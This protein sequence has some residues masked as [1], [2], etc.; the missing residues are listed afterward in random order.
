MVATNFIC[1]K[2][3]TR[4]L[5]GK[6][7]CVYHVWCSRENIYAI[8]MET[9]HQVDTPINCQALESPKSE[10]REQSHKLK[11]LSIY[12]LRY[13][14]RQG[15]IYTFKVKITLNVLS[16]V[17]ISSLDLTTIV[18]LNFIISAYIYHTK[19]NFN[20]IFLL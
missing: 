4:I 6:E 2:S 10:Q 3:R 11:G 13:N 17:Y 16:V 5:G 1:Q 20:Y 15:Y 12:N 8:E 18:Y 14:R 9:I 19:Y 7:K